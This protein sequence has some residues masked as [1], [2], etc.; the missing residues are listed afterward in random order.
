MLPDNSKTYSHKQNTQIRKSAFNN[1]HRGRISSLAS[2]KQVKRQ[3]NQNELPMRATKQNQTI[4]LKRR[5]CEKE[6]KSEQYSS[7]EASQ[8]GLKQEG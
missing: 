8:K 5:H 2:K 1:I 4:E 7:R 6:N 3:P